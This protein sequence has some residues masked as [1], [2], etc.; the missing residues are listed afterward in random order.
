MHAVFSESHRQHQP[1]R[2]LQRGEWATQGGN[3]TAFLEGFG[4]D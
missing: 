2:F 4:H 3:L 1:S